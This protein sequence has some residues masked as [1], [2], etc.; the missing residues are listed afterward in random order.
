MVYVLLPTMKIK[1]WYW[2]IVSPINPHQH[3]GQPNY[4]CKFIKCI[5]IPFSKAH[6]LTQHYSKTFTGTF[7]L[8]LVELYITSSEQYEEV[9]YPNTFKIFN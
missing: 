2:D 1:D 9:N 5:E 7:N 4:N 6:Y 8:T 3:V